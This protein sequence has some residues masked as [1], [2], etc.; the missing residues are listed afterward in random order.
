MRRS[1]IKKAGLTPGTYT[2]LD[3]GL[4]GPVEEVLNGLTDH[5][6]GLLTKYDKVDLSLRLYTRHEEL[7][8][9]VLKAKY[10]SI[11]DTLYGDASRVAMDSRALWQNVTP[12]TEPIR[13]LIEIGIKSGQSHGTR[14][15]NANIDYLIVLANIIYM[16]DASW[17]HILHG[18]IPHEVHIDQD[19]RVTSRS[20]DR[21]NEILRVYQEALKSHLAKNEKEWADDIQRPRRDLSIDQLM[22]DPT[23]KSLDT[24]LEQDRGYSMADWFGFVAGLIDSFDQKKYCEI[25]RISKLSKFLSQKWDV[26]PDRLETILVD[27]G[28]S[29]R[30]LDHIEMRQLRPMEYARRDSRL[31]RR[32][33]VLLGSPDKP[34]C[35]Y[36][37]ETLEVYGR[38]FLDR[39]ITGRIGLPMQNTSPLRRAIGRIQ[40]K[41][42]DAF[43]DRI[44]DRCNAL[45]YECVK[46]KRRVAH[47]AT[48]QCRGFGPVDVFLIDRKFGRFVL[49]ETKDVADSG[50]VPRLIKNEF[51]RFLH[52][53]RKLERQINWFDGHMEALK[54]EF[55]ISREA[56]YEV[57]GV[58]VISSPR[59]WMYAQP[60][61]LLVVDEYE[62]FRILDKGGPFQTEPV[63]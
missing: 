36:G 41:L 52:A 37:I 21:A 40:T 29:S 55:G 11:P 35:I 4:F 8:G 48:S 13:W 27:H 34:I 22:D 12:L 53:I 43:R 38:M 49:V 20:T 46:E 61:P 57:V 31:L 25:T 28:L 6:I 18:V 54:R 26:K 1:L 59:I 5:L 33:V 30:V 32:P 62:F 42:G 16:W 14:P 56:V 10:H 45:G 47:E 3:G 19:F 2:S 24:P 50:T 58:I 7:L 39:L 51:E 23:L 44:A 63:P 9:H 17:E 60:E 15:G